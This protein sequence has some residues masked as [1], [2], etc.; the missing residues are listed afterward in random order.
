M[1]QGWD[2]TFQDRQEHTAPP[3]L[4]RFFEHGS[5]VDDG[6]S[7]CMGEAKPWDGQ[8]EPD[9]EPKRPHVLPCKH[10]NAG[11]AAAEGTGPEPAWLEEFEVA[12]KAI[13]LSLRTPI[14]QET[15]RASQF[16]PGCFLGLPADALRFQQHSPHSRPVSAVPMNTRYERAW[17]LP[18]PPAVQTGLRSAQSI[19]RNNKSFFCRHRPNSPVNV[20]PDGFCLQTPSQR[21]GSAR[22]KVFD[23]TAETG[24]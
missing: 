16:G 21:A 24:G 9:V 7:L 15:H 20:K 3:L 14:A 18:A 2:A 22:D 8:L 1:K 5:V 4:R 12:S 23:G 11:V 10:L 17:I 13:G 6:E 19:A